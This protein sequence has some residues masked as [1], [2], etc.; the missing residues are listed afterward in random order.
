MNHI[1]IA[2]L[3]LGEDGKVTFVNSPWQIEA[4]YQTEIWTARSAGEITNH[5]STGFLNV[6]VNRTRELVDAFSAAASVPATIHSMHCKSMVQRLLTFET[7]RMNED[8]PPSKWTLR[9]PHAAL[10]FHDLVETMNSPAVLTYA[11]RI[12]FSPARMAAIAGVQAPNYSNAETMRLL[13]Q[14]LSKITT[15]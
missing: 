10:N 3:K 6:A 14:L 13:C 12:N 1:L 11:E 8:D 5:G 2:Y 9:N 4:Q 7:L 15:P